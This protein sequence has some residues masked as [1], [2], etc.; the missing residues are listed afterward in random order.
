MLW[1]VF[2]TPVTGDP[3]ERRVADGGDGGEN[4]LGEEVAESEV[5]ARDFRLRDG[6]RSSSDVD[7]GGVL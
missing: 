7:D 4:A 1:A 2:L 3:G 5:E 6:Y